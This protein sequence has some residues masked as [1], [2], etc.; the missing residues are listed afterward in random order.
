M[1]MVRQKIHGLCFF[2]LFFIL[3]LTAKLTLTVSLAD[4]HTS[5]SYYGNSAQDQISHTDGIPTL[6]EPDFSK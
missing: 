6:N 5:V 4:L 2:L 3:F 1:K